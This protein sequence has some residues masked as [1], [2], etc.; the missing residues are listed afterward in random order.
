MQEYAQDTECIA[1]AITTVQSPQAALG[2]GLENG[3]CTFSQAKGEGAI[4]LESFPDLR[5]VTCT[6]QAPG[7]TLQ[8][9]HYITV[10]SYSVYPLH[11]T[12]IDR[13]SLRSQ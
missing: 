3:P 7:F 10:A 12:G 6:S 8:Y 5:P 13:Q 2:G 9:D 4:P 1:Q 11:S